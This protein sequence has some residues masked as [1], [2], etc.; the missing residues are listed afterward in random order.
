MPTRESPHDVWRKEMFMKTGRVWP[1]GRRRRGTDER[2]LDRR[3][4]TSCLEEV[5]RKLDPEI[6]LA[7]DDAVI[8][9]GN[10]YKECAV[11]IFLTEISDKY[12][13]NVIGLHALT[14]SSGGSTEKFREG[15]LEFLND[16]KNVG[17]YP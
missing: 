12:T 9:F 6:R 7:V 14:Y 3:D 8:I 2:T 5:Y 13:W 4:E 1:R 17:Y 16:R 15:L 11:N 10:G